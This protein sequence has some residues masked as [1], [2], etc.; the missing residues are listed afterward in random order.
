MEVRQDRGDVFAGR[1]LDEQ[2]TEFWMYWM[3]EV[4]LGLWKMCH[5]LNY[6]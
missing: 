1:G 5:Q 4:Y 6:T 2:T 3:D